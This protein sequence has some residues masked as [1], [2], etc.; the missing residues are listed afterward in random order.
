[1][2]LDDDNCIVNFRWTK[3]LSMFSAGVL[4]PGGSALAAGG[5]FMSKIIPKMQLPFVQTRNGC[6][7]LSESLKEIKLQVKPSVIDWT[8]RGFGKQGIA[9]LLSSSVFTQ[10]VPRIC[11][12]EMQRMLGLGAGEQLPAIVTGMLLSCRLFPFA[13]EPS[14]PICFVSLCQEV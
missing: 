2:E 6:S 12:V 1:M 8:R 13:H 5:A 10:G 3:A 14:C 9:E 7:H 11:P 4:R